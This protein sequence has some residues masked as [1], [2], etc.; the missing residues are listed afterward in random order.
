MDLLLLVGGVVT[1]VVLIA[2]GVR[3][4]QRDADELDQTEYSPPAIHGQ[5]G[6]H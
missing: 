6:P 3:R 4:F 5:A 2:R 1:V